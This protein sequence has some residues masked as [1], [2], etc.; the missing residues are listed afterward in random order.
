MEESEADDILDDEGPETDVDALVPFKPTPVDKGTDPEV[1][2]E[3][4]SPDVSLP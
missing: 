1:L 2:L 4:R 3:D